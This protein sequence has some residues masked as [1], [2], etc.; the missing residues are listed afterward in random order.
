M[1]YPLNPSIRSMQFD[2]HTNIMISF[3]F[4]F[5]ITGVKKNKMDGNG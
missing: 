2:I 5:G 1:I 3:V 4:G